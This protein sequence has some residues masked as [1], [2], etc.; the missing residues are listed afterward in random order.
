MPSKNHWSERGRATSVGNADAPVGPRR[1]VFAVV[2][3][4]ISPKLARFVFI[5]LES[6][7]LVSSVAMV[8]MSYV[9]TP[10]EM[11]TYSSAIAFIFTAS[12]VLLLALSPLFYR[13]SRRM[14]VAAWV[15]VFAVIVIGLLTPRL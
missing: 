10:R 3:M 6:A 14:A 2:V 9:A 1:S 5:S 4:N 8:C 11:D 13:F 12:W 7:V 15:T